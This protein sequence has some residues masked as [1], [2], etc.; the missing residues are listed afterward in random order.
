MRLTRL[1]HKPEGRQA[2]DDALP[3]PAAAVPACW[4]RLMST[5][6]AQAAKE[7][8]AAYELHAFG[9][10][11]LEPVKQKGKNNFG[12]LGAMIAD[13]LDTL[14]LFGLREEFDR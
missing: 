5:V 13:C 1:M 7:S 9:F 6:R 10:D 11:E 3:A 12:A 8:W 14:W 4:H 2:E